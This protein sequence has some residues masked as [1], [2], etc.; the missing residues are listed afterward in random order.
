MYETIKRSGQY[1][2]PG[3][4]ISR[5]PKTD[6]IEAEDIAG[7]Q[8]VSASEKLMLLRSDIGRNEQLRDFLRDFLWASSSTDFPGV[9]GVRTLLNGECRL[10]P[11]HLA[12]DNP[13]HL[14]TQLIELGVVVP[15]GSSGGRPILKFL[16]NVARGLAGQMKT[17][18]EQRLRN[19]EHET[20]SSM[21]NNE[22][23][24]RIMA[25]YKRTERKLLSLFDQLLSLKTVRS[26]IGGLLSK[27][28]VAKRF[29]TDEQLTDELRNMLE[30]EYVLEALCAGFA[31]DKKQTDESIYKNISDLPEV[32]AKKPLIAKKIVS[33]LDSSINEVEKQRRQVDLAMRQLKKRRQELRDMLEE[34]KRT[35]LATPQISTTE[36]EVQYIRSFWQQGKNKTVN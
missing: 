17:Q 1:Q 2:E 9:T 26:I 23:R 30:D 5:I 24:P 8:E 16:P 10:L 18:D 34:R 35:R 28:G 15:I 7:I 11:E 36:D 14:I 32:L 33:I 3:F 20:T 6:I 21:M 27:E 12:V 22:K 25:E 29:K 13:I 31:Q 4:D 19:V